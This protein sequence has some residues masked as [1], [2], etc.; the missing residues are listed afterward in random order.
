MK[1]RNRWARDKIFVLL[2]FVCLLGMG[3]GVDWRPADLK[4]PLGERLVRRLEAQ[5]SGSVTVTLVRW[6]FS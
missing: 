2:G 5:E 4:C 1:N 3:F 6:P